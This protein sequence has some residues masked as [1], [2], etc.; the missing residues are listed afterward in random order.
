MI[1][2]PFGTFDRSCSRLKAVATYFVLEELVFFGEVIDLELHHF[3]SFGAKIF[4]Q[5]L[6]GAG[7]FFLLFIEGHLFTK[8]KYILVNPD[9]LERLTPINRA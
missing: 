1:G 4:V 6:E 8:G 7:W 9:L 5:I 2:R 3:G